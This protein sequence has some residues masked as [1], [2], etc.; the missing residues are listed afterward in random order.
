[1]C[2]PPLAVTM[3][4]ATDSSSAVPAWAIQVAIVEGRRS[5]GYCR[6]IRRRSHSKRVTGLLLV[7]THTTGAKCRLSLLNPAKNH[8]AT[9]TTLAPAIQSW[10]NRKTTAVVQ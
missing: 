9:C 2:T 7:I 6:Y 10:A 3:V 4:N 1:M 8:S 5:V